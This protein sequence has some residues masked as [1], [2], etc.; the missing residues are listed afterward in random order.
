[1]RAPLRTLRLVAL[2]LAAAGATA[3]A[4]QPLPD[5]LSD[6]GL[7]A[8]GSI[9]RSGEGV[10]PYAP[11]YPL[12]SDGT[13]KRRWIYLP[14]GTAIDAS[15]P[16]AWE[17]PPGTRLWK[18]FAYG[19]PVETRYLERLDDGRW[20][21]ATYLWNADGRDAVL[22]PEGGAVLDAGPTGRYRVPSRADCL[23]CHEG[24]AVPVLG[25]SALQLSPDRDPL[26]PHA[27]TPRAGDADLR[28][29]V[30]GRHLVN[31]PPEWLATPPR[32]AAP[33]ATARAAL[34]YLHGNCGHCH[35]P[36]GAL[37]GLDLSLAQRADSSE[38]SVAR[39]LQSLLD[40]TSRFRPQ[41]VADARRVALDARN[42]STLLLRLGSTSPLARMP[43]LG[44]QVIDAEGVAL[45]ERWINEQQHHRMEERP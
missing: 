20:R 13:R 40:R 37:D 7:Y 32:I 23:A 16:D 44:V 21:F 15:Q 14:P 1:M 24:P 25:F 4:E 2:L 10:L 5:R 6:T 45:V 42:P 28:T 33:T 8:P 39:T 18:E 19:R 11:Q 29:L 12:W 36:D 41:G 27:E 38:G 3:A 30:A 31:L 17:F 34:G 22:A 26:A 43:P 9:T 35:G